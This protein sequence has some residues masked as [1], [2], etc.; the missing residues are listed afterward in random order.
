[1]KN[2]SVAKIMSEPDQKKDEKKRWL[3]DPA[4]VKR[5]L[6]SFLIF[7]IFIAALDLVFVSHEKHVEFDFEKI[8]VFFCLFGAGATLLL[9]LVSILL[10]KILMRDE[11]YYD[12]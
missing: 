7:S 3:D 5:F 12:H 4:N 10:R 2:Q 8:P 1:M 9:V 11:D 6:Y